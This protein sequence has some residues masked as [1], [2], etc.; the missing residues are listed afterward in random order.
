V[1]SSCNFVSLTCWLYNLVIPSN[2][3]F[4]DLFIAHDLNICSY[5]T[6]FLSN[7]SGFIVRRLIISVFLA[8]TDN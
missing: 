5:F 3:R 1:I 7:D 6:A 4:Y 2:L 8:I